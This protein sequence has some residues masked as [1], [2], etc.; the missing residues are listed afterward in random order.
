ML[1]FYLIRD[2]LPK[3]EYPEQVELEFAGGLDYKSFDNLRDRG[4]IADRFDYYTD[5]RW[6][7]DLIRQINEQTNQK[8]SESD[9][10]VKQLLDLL[11][12]AIQKESGL[13]A[14]CD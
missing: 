14:Y 4:I 1:D 8:P 10:D 13:I 2:D 11:N 9:S 7:T 3:S 12:Q 6:G 5:F